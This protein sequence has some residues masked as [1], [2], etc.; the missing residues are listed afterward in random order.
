MGGEQQIL[1]VAGLHD[2]LGVLAVEH[3]GIIDSGGAEKRRRG[4]LMGLLAV[5]F[6][7]QAVVHVWMEGQMFRNEFVIDHEQVDLDRIR[8]RT[9]RWSAERD[10]KQ[11]GQ[12]G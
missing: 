8:I 3:F 6:H 11:Y 1:D 2:D 9:C 4:D 12:E 5:I 7:M 10:C